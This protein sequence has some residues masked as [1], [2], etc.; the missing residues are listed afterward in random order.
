MLHANHPR[1]RECLLRR[2]S[3]GMIARN[4]VELTHSGT[5]RSVVVRG[6][7]PKV[8]FHPRQWVDLLIV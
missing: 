2:F 3:L 8:E 5:M 1:G 7:D 6:F 4:L